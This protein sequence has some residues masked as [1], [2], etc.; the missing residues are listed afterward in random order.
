M[1]KRHNFAGL[2]IATQRASYWLNHLALPLAEW[3][4]RALFISAR[5][6]LCAG[7]WSRDIPIS[8]DGTRLML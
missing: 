5:A 8:T 3:R 7:T 1:T 4:F 2:V 6:T